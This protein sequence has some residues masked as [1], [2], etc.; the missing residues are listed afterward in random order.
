MTKARHLVWGVSIMGTLSFLRN[1]R[2]CWVIL[3]D[4]AT[5]ILYWRLGSVST[6]RPAMFN[7][8]LF[9]FW[10]ETVS[11]LWSRDKAH[12]VQ[13]FS[14]GAKSAFRT[15]DW[16]LSIA[17]V[18]C[19]WRSKNPMPSLLQSG[20]KQVTLLIS[21]VETPCLTS[22]T[23]TCFDS[24]NAFSRVWFQLNLELFLTMSQNG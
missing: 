3:P 15:A 20:A 10:M 2:F 14:I 8:W 22:L 9:G 4:P 1:L 11:P 5:L 23:M 24:W 12:A 6:I 16:A 17:H 7:R 13:L 21:N 18:Q 19:F